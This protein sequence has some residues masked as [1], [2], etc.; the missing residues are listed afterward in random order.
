MP[1]HRLLAAGAIVAATV[2]PAFADC[3][4]TAQETRE[5]LAAFPAAQA[6]DRAGRTKEALALYVKAQGFLCDGNPNAADAA[7]RAAAL[8]LPLAT[9]AEKEGHLADAFDL[10]EQGGHYAAA[11][12]A[13]MALLRR[14]PDDVA[15]VGRHIRHFQQRSVPSFAVNH[16]NEIRAAGP[17]APDAALRRELEAMPAQGVERALA[18]EAVAFDE[19]YLAERLRLLQGRPEPS[20]AN[21]DAM[22]AAMRAEEAFHRRWPAD[23][24]KQSQD[25]LSRARQWAALATDDGALR[26]STDARTLARAEQRAATLVGQYAGAPDLLEAAGNY[27]RGVDHL[28]PAAPRVAQIGAQA[29]TLGDQAR[30]KGRLALAL[31]YYRVAGADDRAAAVRAQQQQAAL[32]QAQPEIDA[33]RRAAEA[34]AAQYADPATVEAMRKEAAAAQAAVA[35]QKAATKPK[36]ASR[37]QEKAD[38][39]RELGLR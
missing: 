3:P 35:Q 1:L 9:S 38:L 33:A 17:Y 31:D 16:A 39:E 4:V 11:D 21:L 28:K 23:L 5:T 18:S 20:P 32:Q 30:A 2:S 8:A 12:K 34:M 26:D 22:Q 36:S 14:S 6:A 10:Y 37:E 7:R 15:L 19:Q 27:Y 25:L 29:A 24:V 13:L